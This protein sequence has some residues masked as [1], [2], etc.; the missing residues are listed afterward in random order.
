MKVRRDWIETN[1]CCF[2]PLLRNPIFLS[3]RLRSS[4]TRNRIQA[5]QVANLNT[6]EWGNK[7]PPRP[8]FL[9]VSASPPVF[10]ISLSLSVQLFLGV[11]LGEER[12]E[13]K[14]VTSII[15]VWWFFA[16][17]FHQIATPLSPKYLERDRVR[18][19]ERDRQTG[20]ER[21]REANRGHQRSRDKEKGEKDLRYLYMVRK[22][23]LII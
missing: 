14:P 20:W 13:K 16:L 7:Q 12:R 21:E 23:N 6:E 2:N 5:T 15:A 19:R 8:L 3:P 18:E 22:N 17:F 1:E 10:P 11:D 9:S 4:K